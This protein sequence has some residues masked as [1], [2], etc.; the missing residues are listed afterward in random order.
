MILQKGLIM[1]TMGAS[2]ELLKILRKEDEKI[3]AIVK[4]EPDNKKA[5][6]KIRTTQEKFMRSSLFN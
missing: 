5:E 3:Y 4:S 1:K 6:E 2:D